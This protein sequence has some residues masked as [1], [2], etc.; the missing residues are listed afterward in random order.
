MK[1]LILRGAAVNAFSDE[2]TALDIAV[3]ANRSAAIDILKH[4]GAKR[5]CER[6]GCAIA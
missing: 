1:E 4:Y 6:F 5:A 3:Q 2:G